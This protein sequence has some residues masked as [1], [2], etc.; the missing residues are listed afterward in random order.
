MIEDFN[1]AQDARIIEIRNGLHR[2]EATS[3][4]LNEQLPAQHA[5]FYGSPTWQHRTEQQHPHP[6]LNHVMTPSKAPSNRTL[7]RIAAARAAARSRTEF[8]PRASPPGCEPSSLPA[9][10]PVEDLAHQLLTRLDVLGIGRDA[11]STPKHAATPTTSTTHASR[12]LR[13]SRSP[14][15]QRLLSSACGS[16]NC[17]EMPMLPRPDTTT[18]Q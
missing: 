8:S 4:D 10:S 13:P 7:V 16:R 15:G 5:V 2:A 9:T 14:P 1:F 18:R 17:Q 11:K 6:M 12:R 3:I